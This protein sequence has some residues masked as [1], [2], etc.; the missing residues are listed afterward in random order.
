MK[1]A[2]CTGGCG[3]IGSNLVK[4]LGEMGWRVDVVDDMSGGYLDSLRSISVRP[5]CFARPGS[6]D[7]SQDQERSL[8]RHLSHG[9]SSPRAVQR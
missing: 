7:L 3:F 8:R 6:E 1:R 9:S 5:V 2:L 4:R